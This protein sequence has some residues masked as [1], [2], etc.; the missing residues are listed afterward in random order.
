ME[1]AL[2]KAADGEFPE[3]QKAALL[4]RKEQFIEA[5]DDDLNT[6]DAISALFELAREINTMTSGSVLAPKGQIAFAK[7]IFDEMCGVLGLLYQ[8]KDEIPQEVLKLVVERAAARKAKDFAK[9]D[10]LRDQITAMGYLV[11]ETR[12]GTR[13]VKK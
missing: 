10:A 5:M 7:G 6:A 9:A 13:V 11:E 1:F 12:Q 3:E 2:E 8:K 4:A